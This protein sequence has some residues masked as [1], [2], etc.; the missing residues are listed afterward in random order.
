MER[1]MDKQE[2]LDYFGFKGEYVG[3][4]KGAKYVEEDDFLGSTN[5][6]TGNIKYGDLAFDSYDKLKM[7]YYKEKF[8]SLRVKNGIK[9]ETQTA[10]F[11][12]HLK[13][14]PEERLGF[15]HAYKNQGL[16]PTH[17]LDLMR[18][19]NFYQSQSFN[20]EKSKYFSAKWWH[21]IYKIQRR[22]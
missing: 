6:K 9:L 2:I 12:K 20:L 21:F 18:H 15:I 14:Y 22:W 10:E 13:F 8:H 16:Y 4:T 7:T 1:G 3:T 11:G 17:G 19:I 5:T